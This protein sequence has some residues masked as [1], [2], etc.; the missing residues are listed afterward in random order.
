MNSKIFRFLPERATAV[1]AKP[2][3]PKPIN[4]EITISENER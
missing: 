2:I 4:L 1:E 3:Q